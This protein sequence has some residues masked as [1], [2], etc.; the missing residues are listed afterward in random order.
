MHSCV[1]WSNRANKITTRGLLQRPSSRAREGAI[2]PDNK[3]DDFVGRRSR[4]SRKDDNARRSER[5]PWSA[6]GVSVCVRTPHTKPIAARQRRIPSAGKLW[7]KASLSIDT[8]PQRLEAPRSGA[9]TET[10]RV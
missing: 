2:L 6:L 1:S 9:A 4:E 7:R 8:E 3:C 10:V 5:S